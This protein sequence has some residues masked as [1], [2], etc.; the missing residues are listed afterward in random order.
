MPL[1]YVDGGSV[2]GL[3]IEEIYARIANRD[4][5]KVIVGNKEFK[6]S[7]SKIKNQA[8]RLAGV[9]QVVIMPIS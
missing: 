6:L 9:E 1:I 5:Y 3:S 7:G 4:F 8:R 2:T